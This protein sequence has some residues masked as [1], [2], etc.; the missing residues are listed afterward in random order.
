MTLIKPNDHP[1]PTTDLENPYLPVF[2]GHYSR[3]GVGMKA[4]LIDIGG[5]DIRPRPIFV[6]L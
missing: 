6:T 5:A 4:T 3:W 2:I 1:V